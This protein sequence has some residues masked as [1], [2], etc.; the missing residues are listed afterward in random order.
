MVKDLVTEKIG[1]EVSRQAEGQRL[2]MEQIDAE[3]CLAAGGCQLIGQWEHS[4]RRHAKEVEGRTARRAAQNKYIKRKK[5][6]GSRKAS[7]AAPTQCGP[8]LLTPTVCVSTLIVPTAVSSGSKGARQA[9]TVVAALVAEDDMLLLEAAADA[10]VEVLVPPAVLVN[11]VSAT[12]E[13]PGVLVFTALAVLDVD[14]DKLFDPARAEVLVGTGVDVAM[15][16]VVLDN[17]DVS[18]LVLTVVA[19][20]NMLLLHACVDGLGVAVLVIL[21]E[22]DDV[23]TS[24]LAALVAEDDVLLLEAAADADAKVRVPPA[25]LVNAVSAT[26]EGS[27]VLAFTALA[28]LDVDGDELFDPARAEVLVGTGVDVAM[29]PVVLDYVDASA[30]VLTAVA[31]ED[32]LLLEAVDVEVE[33]LVSPAVLE[34]VSFALGK[35]FHEPSSPVK[36][37]A[38]LASLAPIGV[39]TD[40]GGDVGLVKSAT[41]EVQVS[42]EVKLDSAWSATS[43]STSEEYTASPLRVIIYPPPH[44]TTPPIL[45]TVETNTT[46]LD[47][48]NKVAIL[49]CMSPTCV[50]AHYL[51]FGT[52]N[53][54]TPASTLQ[55]IRVRDYGVIQLLVPLLGGVVTTR[56]RTSP[57]SISPTCEQRQ[58]HLLLCPAN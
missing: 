22:V 44:Q 43:H 29:N 40:Y 19:D 23:N 5:K 13:G 27:G 28:V 53:K 35:N 34:D 42:T 17:V 55:E 31:T 10:D 7:Q 25:V 26:V 45:I 30:L 33:V 9:Q 54:H 32:V 49:F 11:A 24:V 50:D 48:A 18:A 14:G 37:G 36:L 1:I 15:N 2:A 51:Y 58:A 4:D 8:I 12:V 3:K 21:E 6:R 47:I 41:I 57:L 56:E 52:R 39:S 38:G 46:A 20:D 16:Q